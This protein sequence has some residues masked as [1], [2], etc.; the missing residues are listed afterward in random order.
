MS[1]AVVVKVLL[2]PI[3]LLTTGVNITVSSG[4]KINALFAEHSERKS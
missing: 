2:L 1:D 4:L 3:N